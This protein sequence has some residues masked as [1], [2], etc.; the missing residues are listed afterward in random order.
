[1][2]CDMVDVQRKSLLKIKKSEMGPA[3][4]ELACKTADVA[5][6]HDSEVDFMM[7]RDICG[8]PS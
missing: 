8:Y 4:C 2:P 1:M 7:S 6:H 3:T 5:E